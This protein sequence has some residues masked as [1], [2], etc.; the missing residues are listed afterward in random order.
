MKNRNFKFFIISLKKNIISIL[1]FSFAIFLIIFS[2]SNLIAAKKG[3][4][5][6]VLNVVPSLFPFFVATNLLNHTNIIKYFSKVFNKIMKPI[7]NVPG[8]ASYAFIVGLISGYPVGAK[9]VTNL[10]KLNLCTKDE[11]E[12]MLCFTNNSGPLFILGT[13]GITLFGNSTIGILLLITHILSAISVGII[14]GRI[15]KRKKTII[16][17]KIYLNNYNSGINYMHCTFSNLGE[18]LSNSIL[19][20]SKTVVTIG[21]F[22]IIFSI[23][24]AILEKSYVLE[25][26]S[27]PALCLLKI[28]KIPIE[29]STGITSGLIELTN[30]VS[31]ISLIACKNI[32]INIILVAFLIGFGG[33]SVLLQVL[34]IISKSDLS[35]KKYLY[36]KFLQG[37]ISAVYTYLFILLIP[38]FNFNL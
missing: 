21:G 12:R 30:G 5:L 34:S 28:L 31:I 4:K 13:V 22:I 18:V 19:D 32:S 7:F 38:G 1:F 23:L 20:A 37:F 17:N 26:I 2:S 8:E 25:V 10:R 24:L 14:L 35:I 36:G 3:L 27:L 15:S 33:V 11:G 29:F 9:I 6:W 16:K